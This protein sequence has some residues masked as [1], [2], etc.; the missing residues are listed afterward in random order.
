MREFEYFSPKTLEEALGYLSKLEESDEVCIIAGGTD[1]VLELNEKR[2]EPNIVMNLKSVNELNYIVEDDEYL[3]IGAGTTFSIIEKNSLVLEN[4]K[5]LAQASAKVGSTQIRNL[6]TIGGNIV[7]GSACGDSVSALVALDAVLVV[8]SAKGKRETT[9]EEFYKPN[10]N[11]RY[12]G[13]YQNLSGLAKDEILTEIQIKKSNPKEY[14]AFRKLGK[15]KALAKSIM[16]VG[17][18]I[19]FDED[20]KVK[21]VRI[22][23]GAVGKHP[24]SVKSAENIILNKALT[25]D[26]IEECL[27]EIS[28][29]VFEKIKDRASCPF[30]KESVKGISREVFNSILGYKAYKEAE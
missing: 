28:N 4:A 17:M 27:D 6:G 30:K 12:D 16:T 5:A 11:L 26:V 21:R 3:R 2:I 18:R 7:T 1:V 24:Y 13:C 20:D 14:S 29:V 22:A 23:L 8:Q 19:D 10:P 9:I 25:K 15:R